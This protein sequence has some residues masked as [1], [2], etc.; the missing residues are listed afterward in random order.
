[1]K[2]DKPMKRIKTVYNTVQ[3]PRRQMGLHVQVQPCKTDDKSFPYE[4]LYL[5]ETFYSEIAFWKC[6]YL[7]ENGGTELF[8]VKGRQKLKQVFL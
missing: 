2:N 7:T 6:K 1:M 5:K 8:H 3:Y 4:A